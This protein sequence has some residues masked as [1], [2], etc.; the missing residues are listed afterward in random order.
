MANE[1]RPVLLEGGSFGG[2][3]A[4]APEPPG[5]LRLGVK[6]GDDEWSELYLYV[7]DRTENHPEHGTL[8]VMQFMERGQPL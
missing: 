5:A 3:V 4:M 7:I 6:S 1:L 2:Q 8:P